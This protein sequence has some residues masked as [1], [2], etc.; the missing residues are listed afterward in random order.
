MSDYL[1][2][3]SQL[4]LPF[5]ET[6]WELIPNIFNLLAEKFNL[7]HNSSQKL[8]DLG[9][10]NGRVVIYS[11]L[12]YGIKSIGIEINHNLME[13]A[14]EIIKTLKQEK[15]YRKELFRLIELRNED[16]F[17]QNLKDYD[18]IY[19][20]SLPSMQKSLNHVF[21]TA[22]NGAIFISF[23][24]EL[25]GFDSYLQKEYSL[26]IDQKNKVWTAY[27]YKKF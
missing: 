19:I 25:N 21:K 27:Y 1:K 24:Y 3:V 2:F 23:K 26:E 4:S 22:K 11:A 10:G 14:K 6:P 8:I 20:Y 12:N 13:E 7:I 17:Q 18:F 5:L 16:L 15:S 9:A